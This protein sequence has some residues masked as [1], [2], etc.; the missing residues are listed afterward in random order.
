[1]AA[2]DLGFRFSAGPA[3]AKGSKLRYPLRSASRGKVE[4]AAAAEAPPS[5]S[6]PRR[7]Y[8]DN[9]QTYEFSLLCRDHD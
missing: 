7:Y 9:L 5:G 8:F 4:P 6:A 1:M 2:A 3:A